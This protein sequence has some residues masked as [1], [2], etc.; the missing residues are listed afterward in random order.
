MTKTHIQTQPPS[1]IPKEHITDESIRRETAERLTRVDSELSQG[2]DIVDRY[3]NTVSIFGSARFDEDNP[4]YEKAREISAAL[5]AAGYVPVTGGGGGIMEAGNRGAFEAGGDTLGF[6]IKLPHEQVLND[7][8]TGSMPFK[9]FF[10]RKVILAYGA[11]GYIYFPGGFGTMDEFFEVLTLV[12][13]H[14]V[15]KAPIMLVGKEFWGGLD[16]FIKAHMLAGDKTISEGDEQLYR[17]TDDVDEIV[18]TITH[19]RDNEYQRTL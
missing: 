6:N 13:T 15:P 2:F 12:Q 14:K 5:A 9:Y 18:Q 11:T 10:T 8:T 7:Y 3:K 17:I 1:D 4:H 16:E 19:Y